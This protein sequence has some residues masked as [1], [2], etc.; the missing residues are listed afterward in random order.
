M[1][2]FTQILINGTDRYRK[3]D[4]FN[5]PIWYNIAWNTNKPENKYLDIFSFC[6]FALNKY[7][8]WNSKDGDI[9]ELIKT[10]TDDLRKDTKDIFKFNKD[11]YWLQDGVGEMLNMMDEAEWLK[12]MEENNAKSIQNKYK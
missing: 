1:A 10:H 2:E 8:I 6:E 5:S 9:L 3:V 12:K 11:R 7:D 4:K